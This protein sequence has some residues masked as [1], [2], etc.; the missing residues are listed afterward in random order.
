ML[1][2][3]MGWRSMIQQR[4]LSEDVCA[5]YV[6]HNGVPN[7]LGTEC[8]TLAQF[9]KNTTLRLEC[10]S[11]IKKGENTKTSKKENGY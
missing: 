1:E 4:A 8:R 3:K 7:L 5:Q 10:Q 9:L 6:S 2:I 11:V